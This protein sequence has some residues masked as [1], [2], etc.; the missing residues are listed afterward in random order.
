MRR[1]SYLLV[2]TS[3]IL[4]LPIVMTASICHARFALHWNEAGQ[5]AA[6]DAPSEVFISFFVL[7]LLAWTIVLVVIGAIFLLT[8]KSV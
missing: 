8:R 7:S 4:A 6:T 5:C 3:V 1:L 2:A